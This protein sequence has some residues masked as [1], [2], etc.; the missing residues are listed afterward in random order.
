[1]ISSG[2]LE[3]EIDCPRFNWRPV[4]ESLSNIS[5]KFSKERGLSRK[6]R[7][8]ESGYT[9]LPNIE[10]I[11]NIDIEREASQATPPYKRTT[12]N[13]PLTESELSLI[14]RFRLGLL[15]H[16]YVC[17]RI[18]AEWKGSLPFFAFRCPVHGLVE[19]YP[20]GDTDRL[21]CPLCQREKDLLRR[22]V[23]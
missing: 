6:D 11:K 16:V 18:R 20:H 12:I 14:Q 10:N 22:F 23:T 4:T 21:D 13:K 1:M 9:D 19:D 7:S 8:R 5:I 2:G 15:G 17:H 3:S